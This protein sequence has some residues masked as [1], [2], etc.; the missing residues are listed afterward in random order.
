MRICGKLWMRY[1]K[2]K[3]PT[4]TSEEPGTKTDC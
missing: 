2:T 4:T 1:K 3:N